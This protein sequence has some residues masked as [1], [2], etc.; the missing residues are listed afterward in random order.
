MKKR[1]E[2]FKKYPFGDPHYFCSGCKYF[3]TAS[4]TE[5]YCDEVKLQFK[6][7]HPIFTTEDYEPS[8]EE[9]EEWCEHDVWSW[10]E[11]VVKERFGE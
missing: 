3:S 7:D 9:K 5:I 4:D 2:S 8:K 1:D 10:P 11:E 6:S